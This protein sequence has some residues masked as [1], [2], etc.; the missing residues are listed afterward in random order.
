M[1]DNVK[2]LGDYVAIAWRRKF[3]ILIPFVVVLTATV[4]TIMLMPPVYEA[5]GRILIESQQIPK[6]LIQSTIT[7]FA[8]ERLNVIQQR[9]MTGQ[10]LFGIIEKFG[11]YKDEIDRTPRSEILADMRQR[12]TIERVSA[13]VRNQRRGTSA[14][15][16]FTVSFEHASPGVAQRVANELITL[17]LNE[18][19]R[20]R[21]AR[22]EETSEFLAREGDRLKADIER[23]QEQIA[24]FKEE[25]EG[26]L[27]ESMRLNLERVVTL[28]AALANSENDIDELNENRKL[29]EIELDTLKLQPS[30][31]ALVSV[32]DQA[33]HEELRILQKQYISLSA[34]YGSAHPDVKAA[35]RQL[36]AFQSEYGTLGDVDD[37]EAQREQ[38]RQEMVELSKNYS[39]EHP[40]MKKL[41]REL[42]SVE[43]MITSTNA[44]SSGNT[45]D[46]K[47]NPAI[48]QAQAKIDAIDT[49]IRRIEN[50]RGEM[51]AQIDDL[52]RRVS[53]TP[54]VE[55]GLNSLERDYE[56]T[57]RKYQEIKAK[58]LQAELSKSL[59]E[60]QKGERFTL[61]E[62]P[63]R[64]DSPIKPNRT[65][66]LA[67]GLIL[68]MASG[69]G[70]ATLAETLD[71]GI[72][73]TR[74]L[75]SV[76]RMTPLVAIP[77]ITTR[78]DEARRRLNIRL[79]MAAMV[80]LGFGFVAAVHLY[81]KPLDML[82]FIVLRKFNLA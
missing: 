72:R 53:K 11:L 21:T 35:G 82:L 58:Q 30:G 46:K 17:F 59:E 33:L 42:E 5:S 63:V 40:D 52:E 14:L 9:I 68:S 7:T 36:E 39:A 18:N 20:S 45:V 81:Y 26:S 2:S 4:A 22:A 47:V 76:T 48:L 41:Q 80:L 16:A 50:S 43:A 61:L 6:E 51:Q 57:R 44:D 23:M 71:S 64:P 27:P 69:V 55:R 79:A 65:K 3:H 67:L 28:K 66:L 54:Q 37:L 32:E 12:I 8:D 13:N 49:S 19:I 1:D 10:Q 15:I 29:L 60:E 78:R 31:E 75:A 77:Y 56:N 73:G 70:V 38:I 34:R 24:Q 74:A 62:P 25:N